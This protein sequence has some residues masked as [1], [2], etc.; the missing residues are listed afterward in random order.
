MATKD[1]T[2]KTKKRVG[3]P[4]KEVP[5]V[6]LNA[7]VP[8]TVKIAAEQICKV[9]GETMSYFTSKAL[10]MM[11]LSENTKKLDIEGKFAIPTS[12]YADITGFTTTSIASKVKAGKL[13]QGDFNGKNVI[14]V[15]ATDKLSTLFKIAKMEEE[16]RE[17]KTITLQII[18][19]NFLLSASNGKLTETVNSLAQRIEELEKRFELPKPKDVAVNTNIHRKK[20]K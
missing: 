2:V 18:Q 9:T 10:E 3:R 4:T 5:I 17:Y 15:D 19:K 7:T 11:I 1:S 13:E 14:L 16:H 20:D 12:T 6:P 8:E